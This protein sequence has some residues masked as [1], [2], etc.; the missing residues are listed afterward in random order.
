MIRPLPADDLID[1]LSNRRAV[2]VVDQN[3]SP[4]LGGI[5]YHELASALAT[6]PDRPATIRSFVGGLGGKDISQ[7]ELDH[8]VNALVEAGPTDHPA[9]SELLFTESDW[10][11]VQQRLA[12]AGK[13]V[14]AAS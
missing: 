4:G 3:I 9:D 10:Q 7:G 12:L 1:A 8:V 14:E 6:C 11:M 5:L 2:G 13:P